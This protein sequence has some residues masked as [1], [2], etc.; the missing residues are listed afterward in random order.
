MAAILSGC[1]QPFCPPEDQHFSGPGAGEQCGVRWI[2][3]SSLLLLSPQTLGL[4][5]SSSE[6]SASLPVGVSRAK[7]SPH[8]ED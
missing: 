2:A 4:I 6:I 5:P 7:I 8:R 1:P 3:A